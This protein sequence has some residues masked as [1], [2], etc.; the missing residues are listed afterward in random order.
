MVKVVEVTP[1]TNPAES[2]DREQLPLLNYNTIQGN[3]VFY[4]VLIQEQKHFG[5]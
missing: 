1:S 4:H 2:L 3:S 5:I